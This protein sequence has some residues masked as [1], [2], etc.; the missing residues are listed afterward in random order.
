MIAVFLFA[1]F[2]R[3]LILS[4]LSASF[5]STAALLLLSASFSSIAALP[6]LSASFDSTAILPLLSAVNALQPAEDRIR[7]IFLSSIYE[8]ADHGIFE[9]VIRVEEQ[10]IFPPREGEAKVPGTAYAPVLL[11]EEAEG[12]LRSQGAGSLCKAQELRPCIIRRP[13]VDAQDLKVSAVLPEEGSER[14]RN[15]LFA[16][17]TGQDHGYERIDTS[18][19]F[20]HVSSPASSSFRFS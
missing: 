2:S 15:I 4:L 1:T 9:E 5:G 20:C 11:P 7:T 16:V 12:N 17:I 13:V 6:L 18:L 3:N 14:L 8:R 10:D 19:F